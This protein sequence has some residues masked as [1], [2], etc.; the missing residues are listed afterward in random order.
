MFLGGLYGLRGHL[1]ELRVSHFDPELYALRP[2]YHDFSSLGFDT[3]FLDTPLTFEERIQRAH[4]VAAYY[5]CRLCGAPPTSGVPGG[6]SRHLEQARSI[7]EIL[8]R[9][10]SSH[11]LN[12]PVKE[13]HL[14]HFMGRAL[15]NLGPNPA[16]LELFCAD[17]FYS[18]RIKFLSPQAKVTG[19]DLNGDHVRRAETMAGCLG[20]DNVDFVKEDVTAFLQSS[21]EPY[22]FVLCAGGLYHVNDPKRLLLQIGK[23]ARG[24]IVLQSVVTLD[25]EDPNYFLQPAPGWQHGCRFTHAWLRERLHEIGWRLV[26]EA[27]AELPGNRRLR[28]RGSSFFLCRVA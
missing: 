10:P 15:S 9:R 21:S 14:L 23:M 3:V 17:G 24:Y 25:T 1:E 26:D 16:C 5:L 19:V 22:D 7:R 13:E 4:Q 27:R 2:W 12:Q 11:L 18:C 8:R 20:L 28:D 6:Q